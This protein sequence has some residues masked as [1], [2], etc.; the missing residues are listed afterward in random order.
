MAPDRS[1]TGVGTPI[2]TR[3]LN[4]AMLRRQLL[5]RRERMPAADAIER[6]VGMQTQVPNAPYVGLWSR[7]EGFRPRELAALIEGRDAVRAGLMRATLHLV[8]ARDYLALRPVVAQVLE[9]TYS[10]SSFAR[11]LD[12]VDP[13]ELVAAGTALLAD[14]PLTR[15]ELGRGLSERFPG[16][17]AESLG[18]AF[19]F[20]TPIVQ[21]PPRGVWGKTGQATWA[22]AE[23]WLDRPL[24]AESRPGATVLRYLAAFGP[25]TVADVTAWSGL[26]RMR[27]VVEELRPR[28]RALEDE[29]GRELFDVPDAPLPDSGTAA[30]PRFLPEFDNV[31]VAYADRT[32]VI[33]AEHRDTV[34]HSL[35]KPTLLVDGFVR[36]F[37]AIE[38]E[39]GAATLAIEP[40]EPLSKAEVEEVAAE[41]E[42]LLDFAAGGDF[43]DVRF[44]A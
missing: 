39:G 1:K 8:T 23:A 7:L 34:V 19:A 35:G 44:D 43:H 41:G 38:R 5:L 32:R 20:L 11:K 18:S 12:G 36:G 16:R 30:P 2:G 10:S 22:A 17:E 3:T 28:L 40:L 25:A 9:R 15:A 37:W 14:R 26:T 31:L 29:D 21:V 42:R 6:L 4:R 33:P 27:D 24:D 13:G